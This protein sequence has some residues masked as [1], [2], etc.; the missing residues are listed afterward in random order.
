MIIHHIFY[1]IP[2]V[3]V[4]YSIMRF[5]PTKGNRMSNCQYQGRQYVCILNSE[6]DL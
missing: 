1:N 2:I 4:Y 5:I 3:Q 6:I